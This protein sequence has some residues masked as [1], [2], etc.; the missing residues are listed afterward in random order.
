MVDVRLG[1]PPGFLTQD[2]W[3]ETAKVSDKEADAAYIFFLYGKEKGCMGV[4]PGNFWKKSRRQWIEEHVLVEDKQTGDMVP[5]RLNE[6]Q[7][8]LEAEILRAE[9]RGDPV[10]ISVL[11]ARQQ[12]IST[13]VTAFLLW[14]LLTHDGFRAM[15]MGH[16][17][18]SAAV[19]GRRIKR[20][21][22]ALRKNAR[23][24]YEVQVR[25]DKKDFSIIGPQQSS[26]AIDSA[27]AADARGDT[28]RFFHCIEPAEWP[29]AEE[30]ANATMK[31]VPKAPGTYVIIEGTAHGD[32][33]WFAKT[34]RHAWRVQTY[35]DSS[36][37]LPIRACF[38]PWYIHNNYRW[39]VIFRRPLPGAL[40]MKIES[41]LDDEERRL[42]KQTYIKRGVGKVHVDL[43]QL[44]WRRWAIEEDCQGLVEHFH[45]EYPAYPDEA[46]L[47][48]GMK[49]Y[50][51]RA[52]AEMREKHVS[53]GVFRG[54]IV[55]A[56]GER[57][58]ARTLDQLER[59][60]EIGAANVAG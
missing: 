27:E 54:D 25:Y 42:L 49:F 10:R 24:K 41:T 33:N 34:W 52:L 14:L 44:A 58:M 17:K 40:Q 18:D 48:T 7:R 26:V 20:M 8:L 21:V 23:D 12:G 6:A 59:T 39:T 13:Y 1:K 28:I 45:Q 9:R 35:D 46:F 32:G 2:I 60:E 50:S 56:E 29:N 11:K 47:S 43:D 15:L 30:K 55:D 22:G 31:C 5:F 51:A 53:R 16:K 57:Q 37:A 36:L 3:R 4:R 19:L 38:F